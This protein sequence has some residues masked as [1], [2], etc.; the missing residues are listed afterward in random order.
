[1]VAGP[2]GG[3]PTTPDTIKTSDLTVVFGGTTVALDAVSFAVARGEI[4]GLLGP[5][6]AGKTTAIR[7]LTTLLRPKSG[8]ALVDGHDVVREPER[9]RRAIG[10]VTQEVTV[11]DHLTGYENLIFYSKLQDVP[12]EVRGQRIQEVLGLVGLRER[13]G[14]MVKN[15]SGGMK[16]RLEVAG[17]LVHHPKILFLDEPTLGLDPATRS[18]LWD[19][20]L[21]LR[22]ERGTTIFLTT[23]YMEEANRL[24]DRVC[25]VDRGRIVALGA[26]EEL[27][28]S[29]GGDIIT[30]R[31][32]DGTAQVP[33]DLRGLEGVKAVE[34][35][36]GRIKVTVASGEEMLAPILEVLK[37]S[38]TEVRSVHLDRPSLD[39]VFM[40]YTGR[41]LRAD[42]EPGRPSGIRRIRT[43]MRARR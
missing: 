40:K 29:V 23:H 19:H 2:P 18:H 14:E 42:E 4:F 34:A 6:G 37:G 39:D 43:A 10:Y 7:V 21:R 15:Y 17:A 25:I 24:C 30:L 26:P 1:M 11:E 27:K 33:E 8:T 41:H 12:R 3:H 38:R 5:N 35:S 20:L 36:D 32:A 13:A 9:V 31:M 16:R 28:A 22:D